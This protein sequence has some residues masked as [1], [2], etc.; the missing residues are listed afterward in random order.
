[1]LTITFCMFLGP[2][3]RKAVP[4]RSH[5]E[6][7]QREYIDTHRIPSA[8][9]NLKSVSATMS[10]P[11]TSTLPIRAALAT[12]CLL[13]VLL[14]L[15]A[16]AYAG[17]YVD[18]AVAGL[19][20]EQVYIDPSVRDTLASSTVASLENQVNQTSSSKPLY[21][22]VLPQ[23]ALSEGGGHADGVAKAILRGL[24][25]PGTVLVVSGLS[26]GTSS[27][28]AADSQ[29]A[30]GAVDSALRAAGVKAGKSLTKDAGKAL[31]RVLSDATSRTA[32]ALGGA[33]RSRANQAASGSSSSV[34]HSALVRF[35]LIVVLLVAVVA[36]L[37]LLLRRLTSA[38]GQGRAHDFEDVRALSHQDIMALEEDLG[39]LGESLD[40]ETDNPVVLADYRDAQ[41][42]L[43]QANEAYDR[44]HTANELAPVSTAIEAGRYKLTRA[45]ARFEGRELPQRRP[46]CFFDTRH[47]P[48]VDDVGWMPD[49][50]P[51]RPVPACKDCMQT[52]ASG[53]EP[54]VRTVVSAGKRMPFYDAPP[55]F[56]SWFGGY[57]G[58]AAADL[59]QGFALGR[60]LDDGFAG[61]LNTFGGGYGYVPASFA[62]TGV[63]DAG[64]AFTGGLPGVRDGELV[65]RPAGHDADND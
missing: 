16:P 12:L 47:G 26:F 57:F 61:G 19:R 46:P 63:L 10:R 34:W 7:E 53:A 29:A 55:H 8:E 64:G 32:T 52:V 50:G 14:A 45:R 48:S 17:R 28:S 43:Q 49:N 42:S 51:P 4:G 20:H 18:E 56:E 40:P 27:S 2:P 41:E 65:T 5:S 9:A 6:P 22:A 30:S 35:L 36:L 62:D 15:A 60:A 39:G 31:G 58:G 13:G 54:G 24:H 3:C 59:V 21:V 38:Q 11:G 23:A 33:A 25:R 1:L 44:A 37:D